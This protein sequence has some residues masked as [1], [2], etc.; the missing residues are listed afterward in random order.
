MKTVLKYV[1]KYG[2]LILSLATLIILFFVDIDTAKVALD[3]ILSQFKTMLLIIPSIFILLGLIDVWVPRETMVKYMGPDSGIKGVILAFLLGSC[4]AG[5]LYGAFPLAQ[6]LLKKGA[7]FSNIMIFIGAWS[8]TKTPMFLFEGSALG[9]KFALIR[10]G[11][12]IIVIPIIALV[13]EKTTK[14]EIIEKLYIQAE[15]AQK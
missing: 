3:S 9:W 11:L 4:A 13:L 12:D 5:P 1:K 10:L 8:T 14:K 15:K 7:K 6:V 2:L